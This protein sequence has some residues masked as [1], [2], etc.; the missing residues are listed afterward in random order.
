ME[1]AGSYEVSGK[2]CINETRWRKPL[3]REVEQLSK[4]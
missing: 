3:F 1:I 4:K 2:G